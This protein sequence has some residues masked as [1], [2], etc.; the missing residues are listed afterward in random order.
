MA[1]LAK[2]HIQRYDTTEMQTY[3]TPLIPLAGIHTFDPKQWHLIEGQSKLRIKERFDR[4]NQI[5]YAQLKWEQR[6]GYLESSEEERVEFSRL[7]EFSSA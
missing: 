1:V 7:E 5:E 2:D 6:R 4:M 3:H